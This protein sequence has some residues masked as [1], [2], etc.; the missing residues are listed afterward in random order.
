[1]MDQPKTFFLPPDVVA[2]YGDLKPGQTLTFKV[3]GTDEEGNVEA[4]WMP[5]EVDEL[6]TLDDAMPESFGG[7]MK[8]TDYGVHTR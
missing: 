5:E 8:G 7:K 6:D 4:E 3:V 1:M 2:E